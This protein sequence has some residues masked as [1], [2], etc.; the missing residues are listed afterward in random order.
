MSQQTP[1]AP[2]FFRR[3]LQRIAGQ[4]PARP[5]QLRS[6]QAARIDRLTAGWF[7]TAVVL[8]AKSAFTCTG[9]DA[10]FATAPRVQA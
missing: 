10:T 8:S 5:V 6:F 4:A 9:T 3:A 2:G 7:A 1:A